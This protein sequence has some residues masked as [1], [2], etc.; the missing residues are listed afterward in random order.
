[1]SLIYTQ[2]LLT[3]PEGTKSAGR[4]VISLQQ[5]LA[6]FYLLMLL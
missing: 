4:S 6:V 3:A 1:M 2:I 5:S